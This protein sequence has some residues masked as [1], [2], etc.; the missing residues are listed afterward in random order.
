MGLPSQASA[1]ALFWPRALAYHRAVGT[2]RG[3]WRALGDDAFCIAPLPWQNS[4]R[5]ISTL[6]IRTLAAKWSGAVAERFVQA[7]SGVVW[8]SQVELQRCDFGLLRGVEAGAS[9]D[10]FSSDCL[11]PAA[12]PEG[13]GRA[14]KW[15]AP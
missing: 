5:R 10:A 15:R 11:A 6:V 12:S 14:R 4:L 2:D 3:A 1:A 13:F 9:G 7:V 8:V